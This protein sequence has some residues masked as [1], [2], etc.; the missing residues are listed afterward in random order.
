ML[1]KRIIL[2]G[3]GC[4]CVVPFALALTQVQARSGDPVDR[5]PALRGVPPGVQIVLPSTAPGYKIITL[6]SGL[7]SPRGVGVKPSGAYVYVCTEDDYSLWVYHDGAIHRL[8]TMPSPDAA[9]H[10]SRYRAGYIAGSDLGQVIKFAGGAGHNLLAVPYSD[11]ITALDVDRSNGDIYFAVTSEVYRLPKGQNT[12]VHITT[13]PDTTWGLA[14]R[15]SQLY[16]SQSIEGLIYRMPKSGGPLTTIASG[17]TGPCDLGFDGAGNLYVC[18]FN[19][20]TIERL[21]AGTWARKTIVWDLGFPYYLGLDSKGN[22]YFSDFERGILYK[23][24]KT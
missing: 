21:R 20:G 7:M 22:I 12:A 24:K 10:A 1:R 8:L 19:G 4:L 6:A 13:L 11:V 15:G 18:D 2:I 17:L 23:V 9:L 16:I 5:N 3:L 14:V